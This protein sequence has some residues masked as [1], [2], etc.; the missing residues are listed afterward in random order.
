MDLGFSTLIRK[1]EAELS[2]QYLPGAIQWCDDHM[3]NAWSRAIERFEKALIKAI[4]IGS[5]EYAKTEGEIYELTVTKL[6]QQYKASKKIDDAN[7]F[8]SSIGGF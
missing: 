7:A 3:N 6:L 5:Y 4:E 2:E 1:L 8:L